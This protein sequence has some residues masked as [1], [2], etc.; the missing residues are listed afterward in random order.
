MKIRKTKIC[1]IFGKQL[2]LNDVTTNVVGPSG[3]ALP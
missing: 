2:T 3:I 1:D